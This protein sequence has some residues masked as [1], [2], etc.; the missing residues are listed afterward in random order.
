ML[1]VPSSPRTGRRRVCLAAAAALLAPGWAAWQERGLRGELERRIEAV[2]GGAPA[3]APVVAA[4]APA[5]G[6]LL[7]SWQ[8]VGGCGASAATGAGPG[9]KWVGPIVTG[10]LFN[11]LCQ[12][13]YT[14]MVK[15]AGK[16]EHQFF[17]NS[18]ITHDVHEKWQI[19]ASIPI[20]YKYLVDPHGVNMD[21]SNSGL[22]D[23]SLQVTRRLGA[24]NDTLLT[25]SLG[26]PTGKHDVRYKMKYL[27]QHQQ[28]GFGKVAGSLSLDHVRDQL[29]GLV[30]LGASA[31]W[32][33][34]ENDLANYRAPSASTYAFTGFFVGRLV[35]SVGL[36]LT[37]FAGHDRDRGQD[38]NSGLFLVAPTVAVNWAGDWIG[39]LVGASFPYQY[40]GLHRTADGPHNPWGWGTWSVSAGVMLAPF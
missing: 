28:L 25:A 9:V 13:N 34:G 24:I 39:L 30:L 20:V 35:P 14:P 37:G 18:L 33:G 36:S 31:S 40:D 10:G 7:A 15:E 22:G 4:P 5:S 38:E 11:L 12:A 2:S 17:L 27:R 1:A 6:G 8:S 32:R 19:G 3:C 23:V 16:H 21:L 26:L 29:W